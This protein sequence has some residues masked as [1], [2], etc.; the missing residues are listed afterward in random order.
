[1]TL[2]F[3]KQGCHFLFCL[4]QEDSMG[5]HRETKCLNPCLSSEQVGV[6]QGDFFAQCPIAP[7]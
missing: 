7:L 6:G 3:I 5:D 1:M 4:S 2:R